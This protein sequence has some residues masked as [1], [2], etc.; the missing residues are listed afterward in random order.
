MRISLK[1]LT[2]VGEVLTTLIGLHAKT[3]TLQPPALIVLAPGLSIVYDAS[4]T[5]DGG[6]LLDVSDPSPVPPAAA[7]TGHTFIPV[8]VTT[9]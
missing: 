3:T 6:F 4:A 8:P 5:A 2:E 9:P 7:D 1:Q